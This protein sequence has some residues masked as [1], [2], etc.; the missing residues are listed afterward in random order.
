MCLQE[1]F[2]LWAIFITHNIIKQ[3]TYNVC[4]L[5]ITSISFCFASHYQD[6][7]FDGTT[8]EYIYIYNVRDAQ[9]HL[10]N[11]GQISI[12]INYSRALA[13]AT[14]FFLAWQQERNLLIFETYYKLRLKV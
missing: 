10:I 11:S 12:T 14:F 2:E 6:C 9:S 5:I 4:C 7:L 8:T 3:A 13:Y 1:Q